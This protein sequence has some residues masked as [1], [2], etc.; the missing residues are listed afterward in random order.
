MLYKAEWLGHPLSLE[1]TCTLLVG[2]VNYYTA[3][4]AIIVG[5]VVVSYSVK[6]FSHQL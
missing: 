3:Q 2:F 5:L 6:L 4:G 1:L